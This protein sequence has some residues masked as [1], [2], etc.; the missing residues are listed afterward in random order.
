MRAAALSRG[1]AQRER[2]LDE[3]L[4][5]WMGENDTLRAKLAAAAAVGAKGGGGRADAERALAAEVARE[6]ERA[7]A[8]E[9]QARITGAAMLARASHLEAE[10]EK[11]SAPHR[12]VRGLCG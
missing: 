9:E 3:E 7:V 12:I 2:A 10:L 6:R 8:A 1:R 11:V 4:G 5:R